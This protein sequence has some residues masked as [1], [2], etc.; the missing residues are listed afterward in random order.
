MRVADVLVQQRTARVGRPLTYAIPD[1]IEIAVG[2]VVR[3][4]LGPR[5][6]Y[7][8]AVSGARES[9][10][11]EGTRAIVERVP[12]PR[13]FDD[14]AL[15]LARW[16]AERYCCSLGEALGPFV[17]AASLP[18]TI[19]RF[20]LAGTPDP[21]RFPGVPPRLLR[22]L[23]EF[24]DGFAL[25]ALLR[26]PEARRA[27][28]RRALLA[29]IATLQRG[30]VLER[31]RTFVAPRVAEAK[32]TFLWATGVAVRGPR[33][34]ALVELAT[35]Q[36]GLRRRD[37]V[38]AGFSHAILA[39]AIR[40]GALHETSE[41]AAR[42][43]A[44]SRRDESDFTATDEQRAAIETIVRHAG[45]GR[46]SEILLQGV[47]G[48][49]KTFVYIRAIAD[50]IERGGRAIVLVPEISLTPQTARRFEAVFGERVAV[51]HSGLS[52][53]ERFDSWHAAGRGE[54]D[55]IVGARSALFAPLPNLRLVVID[56]AHERSYKQD[57]VPRYDALD[58]ARERVRAADGTLVLG[59]ATP[60]L[61]AY[62]RARAGEI[63]HVRLDRR[64]TNLPLPAVHVV[65]LAAEFERGNKRIFSTRLVDALGERLARG[66]K[67]VLFINRRGRSSFMLCRACGV[68][69]ECARCSISLT[70]HGGE[71]LL[72][73]HLCDAQQPL[74][75]ACPACGNGPIREF[76]A[77]TERVADAVRALFP[78]A[79][80]VR[81]DSDTT[82]RV[83]DHARLL[84]EFAERGDVLVGTQ[85]VAKGLD[86]PTV[87][88]AAVVAAD[89]GLHVPDF[90]AAERTFDLIAQVAG[91]SGRARPGE[92]VVQTY[93][94]DHPAVVFAA[95]HDYDAFA[96]NELR[97]R[98][99]LGYPPFAELIY[100]GTIGRDRRSVL[101]AAERYAELLRAL[102]DVDVLGPAPY[103]IARVNDE[104]RFRLA[105]KAT[106]GTAARRFVRETILPIA[107]KDRDVRVAVNVDP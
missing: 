52:E 31:H 6:L 21:A 77:G 90:R 85:M 103:P 51:L 57:G 17:F 84:D 49:G 22:L 72:R 5:E 71:G 66:E 55:V 64:A 68:V 73:C 97:E 4:P 74:P 59:S 1:A 53:R 27:G 39:R 32:E 94:P 107:E 44:A 83:G 10:P 28:D 80:I 100:L 104:W 61:A 81:M 19:D 95:K 12:G 23:P 70:V 88:L 26:H 102:P 75:L 15:A 11:A 25:D 45:S 60:P 13:A 62:R 63:V 7:G 14:D 54:I 89:I 16:I 20:V 92:A 46:F 30:G 50:T 3:V 9:V 58:V 42:A 76:G 105:V 98:S 38:L 79:R 96:D 67:S 101:A 43:H 36:G 82:T 56:E 99:A 33:V 65:D 41:R 37:A 86:F 106:D 8:F 29:A 2:D 34:R 24:E 87:T 18:R 91:R 40:E 93:A 48:S 78:D 69:P 47:T 35:Q